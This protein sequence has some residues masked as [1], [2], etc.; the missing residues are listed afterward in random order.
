M[1]GASSTGSQHRCVTGVRAT[2]T[3]KGILG[4]NPHSQK[5]RDPNPELLARGA[6][7]P[8]PG[9]VRGAAQRP[10]PERGAGKTPARFA[11]CRGGPRGAPVCG[12]VPGL[13]R[14]SR[15]SH[16]APPAAQS[17]METG[18]GAEPR[19]GT[20]AGPAARGAPLWGERGAPGTPSRPGPPPTHPA[21]PARCPPVSRGLL[22]DHPHVGL[23]Q[24][25][26]VP[27]QVRSHDPLRNPR[28]ATATAASGPR[29][30]RDRK[31]RPCDRKRKRGWQ[32][33]GERVRLAAQGSGVAGGARVGRRELC[34]RRSERFSLLLPQSAH[35][36]ERLGLVTASARTFHT[37]LSGDRSLHRRTRALR[38]GRARPGRGAAEPPRP[39]LRSPLC[40][41]RTG[42]RGEPRS[43]PCT[44]VPAQVHE[45]LGCQRCGPVLTL[46]ARGALRRG[47]SRRGPS[48]RA[49]SRRGPS[50]KVRSAEPHPAG[51]IPQSGA[52]TFLQRHQ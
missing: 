45:F 6:G 17:D 46:C 48:R 32:H 52:L 31:P 47:P 16:R 38:A 33:R 50:R 14:R 19:R 10:L 21:H 43:L 13:G 42:W 25:R 23:L 5:T 12:E 36:F 40:S 11:L 9:G 3:G 26:P 8:L 20:A 34:S 37:R 7:R 22:R 27:T 18:R 41:W 49:P 44:H 30:P 15:R 28:S 51:P 35:W 29:P 4:E 1:M 39:H 2:R 24:R